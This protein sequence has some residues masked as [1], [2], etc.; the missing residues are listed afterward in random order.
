MRSV[1]GSSS[2]AGWRRRGSRLLVSGNLG[3]DASE[4]VE[5]DEEDGVRGLRDLLPFL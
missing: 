2:Y 4:D 3:V 1:P 5:E